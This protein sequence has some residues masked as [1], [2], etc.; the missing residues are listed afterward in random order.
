[1]Y[2]LPPHY[3]IEI[4]RKYLI[5]NGYCTVT[6]RLM[7]RAFSCGYLRLGFAAYLVNQYHAYS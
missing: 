4:H 3:T 2:S 6:A 7:A 1:L 5:P